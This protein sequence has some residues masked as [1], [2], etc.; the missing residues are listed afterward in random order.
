MKKWVVRAKSADFEGIAERF[1]ISPILA[2]LIR[3]RDVIGDDAINMYLNANLSDT[4]SPF[5]LKNVDKACDI[6]IEAIKSGKSIRVVGDYDIDGVSASTILV[7]GLK[8]AGGDVSCRLPHRIRDGYGLNDS[9]IEEAGND[10]IDLIITCDNGIAASNEIKHAK[11]LGIDVIITDHHEI[12]FK[13]E[14]GEKHFIIPDASCVINPHQPGET[15]PFKEI[16]GAMVAYKTILALKK[17]IDEASE[18]DGLHVI[19]DD[20]TDTF[21]DLAA[22][23]TIGDVM[24]LIDENRIIVKYGLRSMKAT[25]NVGLSALIDATGINRARLEP[26]HIGFI[27][28]PCINAAGRL[29]SADIAYNLLMS[30]DEDEAIEIANRLKEINIER[31]AIEDEKLSEAFNIIE[32]GCD[33]HDYSNDTVLILYLSDCHESL[34]GLIAGKLKEKYC[35]PSIVLT[36]CMTGLKGSGRSIDCYDIHDALIRNSELF[37]KFGGHPMACG[38]SMDA[39]KLEEFRTRINEQSTLTENDLIDKYYIDID[40]PINYVSRGLI[41][42]IEKMGPF[43]QGNPKPLFAQKNLIILSR[44][45]NAKGNMI[46]LTLKSLPHK[47]KPECVMYATMFGEADELLSRLEGKNQI[48]MAYEPEYNDYFERVQLRIKD[49]I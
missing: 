34:A 17:R 28:G 33:G 41:D 38:L 18:N 14:N 22:F 44:K 1:N 48:T 10:G 8:A 35:K 36:D 32:T 2:R 12:P 39:D 29:Y 27:L 25:K 23:A 42:E 30:D 11:E 37:Q 9:I 43:G 26:Y 15:Y 46:T 20:L 6:I 3:N 40:M 19:P 5:L 47:D 49:F 45:K 21:L 16:C 13:E 7:R 31:R 24:P 4:Y